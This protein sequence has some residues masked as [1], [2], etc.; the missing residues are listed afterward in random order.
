MDRYAHLH[1]A[2]LT[3]ALAALADL[4]IKSEITARATG[5]DEGQAPSSVMASRLLLGGRSQERSAD[6]ERLDLDERPLPIPIVCEV[7]TA[8]GSAICADSSDESARSEGGDRGRARTFD[9]MI[10]SHLLYRLSY[11]A[12]RGRRFWH[13]RARNGRGCPRVA[14]AVLESPGG[15]SSARTLVPRDIVS[16]R[17]AQLLEAVAALAAEFDLAATRGVGGQLA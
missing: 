3:R 4:D 9:L 12:P 1:A 17:V 8:H 6:T 5:T 13:P 14:T 7:L 11:A 2:D 16:T 10:K 15:A